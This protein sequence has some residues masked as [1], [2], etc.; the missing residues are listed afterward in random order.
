MIK[1]LNRKRRPTHLG[2]I[3]R[4]DS[5]SEL[6]LSADDLADATGIS[7]QILDGI[8][9]ERMPVTPDIAHRLGL[10]F[11]MAPDIWLRMQQSFD[12]YSLQKANN[13]IY[14]KIVKIAA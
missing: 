14:E 9:N 5:L 12:L 13:A 6:D 4:E 7:P 1:T 3:L 2:V 8:L 11:E 10:A